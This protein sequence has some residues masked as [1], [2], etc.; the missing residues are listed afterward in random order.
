MA[1]MFVE[2]PY[3]AI[4]G[5]DYSSK[6]RSVKMT[7]G[8]EAVEK[9]AGGDGTRINLSGLRTWR[10]E[11]TLKEDYADNALDEALYALSD[12]GTAFTV[13]VRPSTDAIS[14]SNPEY[15]GSAVFDGPYDLIGGSIGA[16]AEKTVAFVP[17]GAIARD[18]TP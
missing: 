15:G 8:R 12:A 6:V 16:L 3:L 5:V 18:I 1:D 11:A 14:A 2:K 10:V 9:T 4:N 17:A 7:F 13:A